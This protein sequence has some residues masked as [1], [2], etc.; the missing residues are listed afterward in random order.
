MNADQRRHWVRV[1][2]S[3][4]Q[5]TAAQKTVLIALETYADYRDGTHA[6]PGEEN[7]ATLC[8]LT[9]RAVRLALARGRELGLIE[10]TAPANHRAGRADVYRLL[11]TTAIVGLTPPVAEAITGTAVPVDEPITGMVVPVNSSITGTAV[12]VDQVI[13]G[14]AVQDHRN[15]H[16]TFTGT[17]VPPTLHAPSNHHSSVVLRQVGTSPE[18]L[19]PLAHTSER[20]SRFCD[21]HPIGT[22][23]KCGD[24]AN[25]YSH[26]K[27]W[28]AAAA[29][30]DVA[31]AVANDFERRRQRQIIDNC[32]LGCDEYGRLEVV[33]AAGDDAMIRC[34][35]GLGLGMAAD[36]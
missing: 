18:P 35:H 16:D 24:C 5:L 26:Q 6:F 12:P 13:T 34:D 22:R 10:R 19:A 30:A 29:E 9:P 15:G 27:A 21:N 1:V 23:D 11:P 14:T 17:A 4:T 2:L 32:P 7:L 31:L 36:G 28:D 25:A 3:H 8:G 33:N 20:P